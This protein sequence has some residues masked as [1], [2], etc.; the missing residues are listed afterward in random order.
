VE[1]ADDFMVCREEIPA[2]QLRNPTTR[3]IIGASITVEGQ[4]G[5]V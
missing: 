2:K 5:T 4:W 1:Q 3:P